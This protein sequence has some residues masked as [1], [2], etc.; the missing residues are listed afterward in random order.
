[1]KYITSDVV[2]FL[3]TFFFLLAYFPIKCDCFYCCMFTYFVYEAERKRR[4]LDVCFC[5][6]DK[7]T[8][9]KTEL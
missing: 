6:A 9:Q 4:L 3:F 7:K 1:M 8:K 5:P 2:S